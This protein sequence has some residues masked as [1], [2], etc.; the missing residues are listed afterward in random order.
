MD[1]EAGGR[2]FSNLAK[3]SILLGKNGSGKSTL[4]RTFEQNR[5]SLPNVGA[6]RYITPER[7]GQ[8]IYAG[9]IETN[10]A[11]SPTWG[12]DVRRNNRFDNFR[13]LS[14]TEFR[15]L[16]TLVLRKI[17]KDDATRKNMNFSFDT[18]LASIN[19]LL[20]YVQIVRGAN[21]GFDIQAK[22]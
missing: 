7:G 12:D 3:I 2:K 16:E 21:A 11:Q 22:A 5:Q 8:L 1:I 19:Q 17:E 6:V 13:Q 15:R 20:D 4:L 14:V 10:I 18:T 9:A